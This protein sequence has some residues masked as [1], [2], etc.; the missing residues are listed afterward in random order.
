GKLM[1]ALERDD[2]KACER[3]CR[4]LTRSIVTQL[5]APPVRVLV[6]ARRPVDETGEL[7]GFYEPAVGRRWALIT[8]WMRTAK[9]N[10]VVA[11]KS[12]L[13][14]VLHELV[15]HLD[16]EWLGLDETFHT[17]GFYK[18]ESSLFHQVTRGTAAA[19]PRRR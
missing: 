12:F 6:R 17:E 15:H 16:Y 3:A 18:R 13:R 4:E 11:F 9:K 14:T 2:L 8:V 19:R 5:D 7:H 10:Q 1:N